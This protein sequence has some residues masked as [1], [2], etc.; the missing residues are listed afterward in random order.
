MI[1]K[2]EQE[3]DKIKRAAS[4]MVFVRSAIA[5]GGSTFRQEDLLNVVTEI[6]ETL[7]Q[8]GEAMQQLF[9]AVLAEQRGE[10]ENDED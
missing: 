3:I 5:D 8:V 1:L 2:F 4:I 10:V 6:G 9:D 7:D